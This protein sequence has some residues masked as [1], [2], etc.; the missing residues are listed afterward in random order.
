MKTNY[1]SRSKGYY[2]M[3]IL[4]QFILL[5]IL[6]LSSECTVE[7][8]PEINEE[9]ELLVVEGLITD[10]PG[11]DSIKLSKSLP[12]AEKSDARPLSGCNVTITDDLGNIY[13][14]TEKKAGLYV[15]DSATFKGVTGR[16]YALHISTYSNNYVTNY[17]S[18]PME[19]KSVP[20]I[21]SVYYEKTVIKEDVEGF[22]G[23]DGCQIFIDTSDPENKCRYFRWD[24]SE[25]WIL[26]LLFPVPNIKCWVSDKSKSIII[27]STAS[28]A[29]SRINRQPVSYISNNSDRLK[30]KYSILVNQY[31]LNEDEYIFWQNLE[32]LKERVGGLSDIIP[33][34]I[35][36]NIY[37]IENP[38]VQVLGYFSVSAKSSKRIFIEE[39]FSGII[40]NYADCITDT[41]YGDYNPP[42]LDISLWTLIDHPPDFGSPRTRVLT[43][44]KG[45]ADCTVRGTTHK[46]D[47][48]IGD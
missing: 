12:L 31:S 8:I 21:D 7:F 5:Q 25:T 2:L 20:V 19:M 3:K 11:P 28:L 18:Y 4:Q 44:K 32:N 24:Y 10:Q 6:L 43:D 16:K 45:C 30:R 40:N 26:R 36:S 41:I 22:Y 42:E 1:Y 37:C 9:K 15:T 47:F 13:I 38:E 14:L 17:E 33:A 48:W 27:K 39:D 46:P 34:S 23:I 29:E 35:P